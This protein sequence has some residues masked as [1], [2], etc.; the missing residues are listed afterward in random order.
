MIKHIIPPAFAVRFRN[1]CVTM[2]MLD[3]LPEWV[4]VRIDE[5]TQLR[6][7]QY[8]NNPA[9]HAQVFGKSKQEN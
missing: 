8:A 3:A 5:I 7:N 1:F 4:D 6:L 9:I 2:T